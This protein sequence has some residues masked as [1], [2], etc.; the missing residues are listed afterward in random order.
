MGRAISAFNGTEMGALPPKQE[1]VALGL[2]AGQALGEAA[3]KA[4]VGET[5]VKRW[6]AECPALV[7]RVTEIR[8]EMTARALGRLIDGMTSAADTL[9]YLCRQ[10]KSEMVRLG[11]AR[12]LLELGVKVRESVELEERLAALETS[13]TQRRVAG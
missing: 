5:T 11:A 13:Q 2:A 12:A 1:A 10:G 9:G 3:R 7:R 6:L 8:G 4:G